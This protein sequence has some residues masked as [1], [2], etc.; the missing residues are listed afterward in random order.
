[1]N[2]LILVPNLGLIAEAGV[3][4]RTANYF[5]SCSHHTGSR[6]YLCTLYAGDDEVKLWNVAI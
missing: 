5:R 1:V 6:A 3:D 2:I 4:H